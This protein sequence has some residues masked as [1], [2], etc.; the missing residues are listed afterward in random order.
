MQFGIDWDL[1]LIE[2]FCVSADTDYLPSRYA[3]MYICIYR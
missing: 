2:L 3:D 1:G